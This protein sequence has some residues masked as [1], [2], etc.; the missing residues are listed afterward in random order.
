MKAIVCTRYGPPE[1]L[2]LQELE[3][4]SPK[5]NEVLIK[6]HATTVLAGD[7]EMRGFNFPTYGLGLRLLMRIGFGFRGPRKKILGQQLAGMIEE[8]GQDVTLFKKGDQVFALTELS[9]GTYAEYTCLNENAIM[10]TKPSN[11]TYEEASTIPVGGCEALHFMEKGHIQSGQ[12]VLINGAG[13]SIGTIAI[14][15]AKSYGAEVT[16][17]D[18]A[19]KFEMLHSLGADHVIDYKQDDFTENGETYDVIFDVIGATPFEDCMKSL[20]ENGT[21]LLGNGTLSRGKKSH[22]M[23]LDRVAIDGPADYTTRRLIELR[24]LIENGT[25]KAVIDT[26]YP[27]EEMV[28]VHKFVERGGKKGNVVVT[29]A[30]NNSI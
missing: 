21:Y 28:E 6:I 12:R 27:L 19:G 22:A 9:F 13:G 26:T 18:S 7:C 29:M 10:T 8:I 16:A 15:L 24:E 2:Q 17:V 4:P 20:N 25:I 5:N 1:V 3:K 30:D 14:Q 11:M 23:K